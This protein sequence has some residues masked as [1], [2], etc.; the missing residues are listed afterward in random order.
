VIGTRYLPLL[1]LLA[2]LALLGLASAVEPARASYA[3]Y[4][5]RNLSAD[6]GTLLGGTGDE[7]SS[8]WLEIVPR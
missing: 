3:I 7:P 4:V 5:G 2:L 6:G 8:H 1:A